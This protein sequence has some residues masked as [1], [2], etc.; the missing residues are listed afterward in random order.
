M[1]LRLQLRCVFVSTFAFLPFLTSNGHLF[2]ICIFHFFALHLL[3]LF[4]LLPLQARG[5]RVDMQKRSAQD[6]PSKEPEPVDG[7]GLVR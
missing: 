4:L 3:D 1:E 5:H 2:Y 7:P 6:R